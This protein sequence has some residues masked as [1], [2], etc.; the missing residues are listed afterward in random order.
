MRPVETDMDIT[1]AL[2]FLDA[3]YNF[4]SGVTNDVAGVAPWVAPVPDQAQAPRRLDPPSL[5]RMR[6]LL[7]FLG[8]P[9]LDFPILHITGTNGKGSTARMAASLLHASGHRV[10]TY[11]SPHL[12]LLNERIA[13]NGKAI[14][15]TDLAVVLTALELAETAAGE[16]C[17]FF[18]LITAAA[19]R[20]FGDEAVEAGVIE[21]GART[22]TTTSR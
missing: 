22:P 14:D 2:A 6:R 13:M 17:S 4:E 3:H 10:G 18:E 15:D 16:R 9:Q 1:E 11:T 20:Y 21:V 7:A 12:Q 5:E 8:D 19:Y